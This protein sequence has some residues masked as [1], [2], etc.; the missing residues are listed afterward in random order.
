MSP[1]GILDRERAAA[2]RISRAR[3]GPATETSDS[4]AVEVRLPGNDFCSRLVE[5]RVNRSRRFTGHYQALRKLTLVTRW[6]AKPPDD[7]SCDALRFGTSV[8]RPSARELAQRLKCGNSARSTFRAAASARSPDPASRIRRG[9]CFVG[10]E[11]PRLLRIISLNGWRF[12][13]Q[14][15]PLLRAVVYNIITLVVRIA[16]PRGA[17]FERD[18]LTAEEKNCA[19]AEEE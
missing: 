2:R 4:P 18:V 11:Q 10:H 8:T 1:R 13:N 17:L 12:R 16:Q 7:C 15:P 3:E 6:S 19:L 9:G 5:L 14:R